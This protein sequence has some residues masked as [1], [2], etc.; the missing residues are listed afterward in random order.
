MAGLHH[1]EST[2][3]DAIDIITRL[4][5]R[6]S[7]SVDRKEV[8]MLFVSFH[9]G[10]PGKHPLRNNVHAYD[11]NGK[12]ISP[13][14]LD[15]KDGIILDELRG[16]YLVGEYLYV[17]NANR[18][19]NS[20][21]CYQGAGTSYRF[22]SKF[23]SHEIAEGV[24]HPFDFSFDGA[25][26]CYLS[27]QDTN[28]VSR[29]TVKA[30]G[31]AAEAAPLPPALPAQG[32]YLPG[33]FVASSVGNLCDMAT[34][35]VP[36]PQGLGYSAAGDKKHSVRGVL[37]TNGALYVVDQP[38]GKVK[39]YGPTGKL[40]GQSNQVESP[41]HLIAQKDT[42]YV[43]GGDE[44]FTAKLS[45]PAGDL[46]LTAIPGLHVK[47]GGGMAFSESGH[48]YI[49]SR[50]ENVIYKLDSTFKA[51]VFPCELP[52]NPEFLLHLDR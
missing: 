24:L 50:T 5:L 19:Q 25:G 4:S 29:F 34:T 41:V 7:E 8:A 31:K 51:M 44:V 42:L 30:G 1:L 36:T 22:V 27:S 43:S 49:A 20:L 21:L 14:V 23:I 52:D 32:R 17:A 48:L 33:T 45:K 39:A 18:T 26:Y 47:N 35:A 38:A 28:L 12:L 15:D 13:S 10:K 6:F 40:L 3:V 11:K 16:I 37:W 9:G 2:N 46:T